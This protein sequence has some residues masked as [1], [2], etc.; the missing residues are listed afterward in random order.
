[1]LSNYEIKTLQTVTERVEKKRTKTTQTVTKTI[2]TET[3]KT[4]KKVE[5]GKNPNSKRNILYDLL[6]QVPSQILTFIQK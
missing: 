4:R 6:I 2:T 3:I 1:M 5:K